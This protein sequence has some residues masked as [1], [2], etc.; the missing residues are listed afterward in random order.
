MLSLLIIEY[1]KFRKNSVVSLL[2]IMYLAFQ[3]TII[4]IAK[5]FPTIPG[6]IL[7]ND[8]YFEFPNVWDWMGYIGNWLV[9][10]FLGFIS[11]YIITS[12][13]THKTLRQSVINGFSRNKIFLGKLLTIFVISVLAAIYYTFWTLIIG[14]FSTTDPTLSLAFQNEYAGLRFFLMCFGYLSFGLMIGIVI[15]S[16][17]IAV[18]LYWCYVLFLEPLARFGIIYQFDRLDNSLMK[19]FPLNAIEDLHPCPLFDFQA[20]I[21]RK[22]DYEFLLSFQSAALLT[23]LY[24]FIFLALAYLSLVK[25]DM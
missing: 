10:F 21:P 7:S 5:E 24:S 15:R 22:V 19:Y 20:F 1:Q 9:F 13:V 6:V 4:F 3:P 8:Y 25:K 23:I 18:L 12:E 16:A 17:G 14:W 11:V 2:V